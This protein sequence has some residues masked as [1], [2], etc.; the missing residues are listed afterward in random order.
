M[1]QR[2][3]VLSMLAEEYAHTKTDEFFTAYTERFAEL[4]LQEV[5]NLF[6]DERI[7]LHYLEQPCCEESVRLLLLKIQEHFGVKE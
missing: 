2:I 3:Q 4:I 6:G 7:S 5:K 1:N